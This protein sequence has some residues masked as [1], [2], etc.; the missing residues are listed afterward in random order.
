M[1][2]SAGQTFFVYVDCP[3]ATV[4]EALAFLSEKAVELGIADDVAAVLD[5]FRE[6]EALSTTGMVDGISVPHAKSLAIKTPAFMVVKFSDEI[7]GWIS[8]D[9]V[10]IRVAAAV[11]VPEAQAKTTYLDLLCKTTGMFLSD[12]FRDAL[13][14]TDDV[15]ALESLI[16]AWLE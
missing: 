11:L 8:L 13:N 2:V 15:E 6:R 4:D 9:D 14:A 16:A 3:A 1:P 5:A 7:D 12:E 10:P